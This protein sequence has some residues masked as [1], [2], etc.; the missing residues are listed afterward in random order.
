MAKRACRM[1]ESRAI[2][3]GEMDAS[4]AQTLK[5]LRDALP[6]RRQRFGVVSL[7]SFGSRA[8]GKAGPGSD[9]DILV[10]SAVTVGL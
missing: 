10:E 7:R 6:E 5:I 9:A 8:R 4:R 3:L 1:A 2:H